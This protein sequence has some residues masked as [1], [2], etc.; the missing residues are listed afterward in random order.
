VQAREVTAMRRTLF[1]ILPASLLVFACA[2]GPKKPP[3]PT[4]AERMASVMG[5]IEELKSRVQNLKDNAERFDH[6]NWRDVAPDVRRDADEL[7]DSLDELNAV[8]F[9]LEQELIRAEEPDD[10]EPYDPRY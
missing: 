3:E 2:T 6:E 7:S 8:A 9:E 4:P 5:E 1:L 10:Y